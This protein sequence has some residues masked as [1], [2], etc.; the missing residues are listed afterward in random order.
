[1]RLSLL[2]AALLT[3][4]A[5]RASLSPAAPLTFTRQCLVWNADRVAQEWQA[6]IAEKM[7]IS[8]S[9]VIV[10]VICGVNCDVT[11]TILP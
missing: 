10:R 11:A 6:Q 4:C 3:G 9:R 1:M 5:H 8:P 2:F 7:G